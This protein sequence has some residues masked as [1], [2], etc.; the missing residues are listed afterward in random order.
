MDKE[1]TICPA[2]TSCRD[3]HYPPL[4]YLDFL[5]LVGMPPSTPTLSKHLQLYFICSS[6]ALSL[7][8]LSPV[9]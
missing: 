1:N 7:I 4:M 5:I 2:P 9:T 3:H 8:L 6:S